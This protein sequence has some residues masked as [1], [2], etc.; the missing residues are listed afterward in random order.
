AVRVIDVSKIKEPKEVGRYQVPEAGSER[1]WVENAT[2]YVGFRQGGV[3]LVDVGGELRGDLYRQGRQAGWFM[4]AATDETTHR[5]YAAMA[6]AA[7]PFKGYV[8]VTDANSG[9]WVLRHQRGSRLT[10]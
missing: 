9:L 1:V 3:R 2:L 7:M 6:L 5:P 10:P 4:T 8:F